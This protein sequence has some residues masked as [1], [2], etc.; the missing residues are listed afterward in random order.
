MLDVTILLQRIQWK[1]KTNHKIIQV[2]VPQSY[3]LLLLGIILFLPG[4]LHCFWGA[5]KTSGFF[6]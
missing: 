1:L 3:N 4:Y 5:F 2:I 6:I